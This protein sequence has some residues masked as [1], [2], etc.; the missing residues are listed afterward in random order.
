VNL[1]SHDKNPDCHTFKKDLLS[2]TDKKNDTGE[3]D[4][5]EQTRN[6]IDAS[7]NFSS[8]KEDKNEKPHDDSFIGSS[9]S[10]RQNTDKINESLSGAESFEHVTLSHAEEEEKEYQTHYQISPTISDSD[11]TKYIAL[12]EILKTIQSFNGSIIAVNFAIGSVCKNNETVRNYL[13]DKITSRE[14]RNVRDLVSNVI[15][16][17]NIKIIKHKPQLLVKWFESNNDSMTNSQK[18]ETV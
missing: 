1:K 15:R 6:L 8:I 13:G 5:V 16:H 3:Y 9:I 17:P 4:C 7:E 18:G 12:Q 14:N 10:N 11:G 2:D